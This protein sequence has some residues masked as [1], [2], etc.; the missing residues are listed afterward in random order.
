MPADTAC[1]RYTVRNVPT[2]LDR[3]LREQARAQHKSLNEVVLEALQ[4]ALGVHGELP[5]QRHLADITGSWQGDPETDRIL[6]E[7]RRVD[8]ELWR[9]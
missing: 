8:P 5:V 4:R 6:A 9:R 7:Q 2:S 3:A 1:M